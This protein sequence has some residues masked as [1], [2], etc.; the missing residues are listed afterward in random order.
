V[1]YCQSDDSSNDA[2]KPICDTNGA[3]AAMKAAMP[4]TGPLNFKLAADSTSYTPGNPISLTL[5]ADSGFEG[6]LL[7]AESSTA[8]GK[9]VGSFQV[10]PKFQN[11][12]ARCPGSET[13]NSVLTH[14][15]GA[16]YDASQTFTFTPPAAGGDLTFHAILT[17]S[18]GAGYVY[19]VDSKALS[20]KASGGEASP[21]PAGGKDASGKPIGGSTEPPKDTKDTTTP[22]KTEEKKSHEV[23][24]G[25]SPPP[26]VPIPENQP[27]GKPSADAPAPAEGSTNS[28]ETTPTTPGKNSISKPELSWAEILNDKNLGQGSVGSMDISGDKTLGGDSSKTNTTQP[29][30]PSPKEES[31]NS[32]TPQPGV[33]SKSEPSSGGVG[34]GTAAIP[35]SDIINPNGPLSQQLPQAPAIVPPSVPGKQTESKSP[36]SIQGSIPSTISGKH[37][38]GHVKKCKSKKHREAEAMT[39]GDECNEPPIK[40][41]KVIK[42]II[43]KN[44]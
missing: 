37:E 15:K 8:P 14:T 41:V 29:P 6:F 44:C 12:Q 28:S 40:I 4:S 31:K 21:S 39:L 42:T 10:P 5:T 9:K 18:K 1:L 34:S 23:E 2:K 32:N 30:V 3:E 36:A 24:A 19:T 11:N 35:A 38:A 17:N 16:K 43:V 7:Y 13:P 26:P 25:P 22:A 20:L 27:A 33:S